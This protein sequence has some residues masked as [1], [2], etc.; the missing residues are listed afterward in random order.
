MHLDPKAGDA[1]LWMKICNELHLLVSFFFGS[2]ACQQRSKS[3]E[4]RIFEKF[5]TDGNEKAMSWQRK[6]R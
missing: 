5:V 3:K 2:G 1:D 4:C 6:V